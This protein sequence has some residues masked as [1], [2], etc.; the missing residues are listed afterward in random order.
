VALR[1]N[2]PVQIRL[3]DRF[4]DRRII[5]ER[6]EGAYESIWS[7]AP[8][9]FDDLYENTQ[10]SS[11]DIHD[12]A[13]TIA[14]AAGEVSLALHPNDLFE[15]DAA[16]ERCFNERTCLRSIVFLTFLQNVHDTMGLILKKDLNLEPKAGGPVAAWFKYH[17]VCLFVR[18]L[19]KS[20]MADFVTDWGDRLYRR[21]GK[22]PE[23]RGEV[24]RL[25]RSSDPGIRIHIAR[26][27]MRLESTNAEEVNPAFEKCKTALRL[28]DN[29][30]PFDV[31]AEIDA[32]LAEPDEEL[33]A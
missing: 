15:S 13:R 1:A 18:H 19:A 10:G 33:D 23:F 4:K 6:Q 16:Y 24:G 25:L 22:F 29:I 11:V 17:V 20:G 26:Q 8:E 7:A 3:E 2:D 9:A 14:A 12:I 30:N 5:Y 27:F 31:F 21:H 28:K 32:D